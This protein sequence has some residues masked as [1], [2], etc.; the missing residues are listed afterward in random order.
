MS[1]NQ[2]VFVF[3][4]SVETA[5]LQ[6]AINERVEKIRALT[7]VIQLETDRDL[8]QITRTHYFMTIHSL[9]EELSLLLDKLLAGGGGVRP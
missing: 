5:Q 7:E 6:D 9:T 4:P 2:K 1:R 3:N 8:S